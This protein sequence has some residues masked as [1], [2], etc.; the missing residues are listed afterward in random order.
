MHGFTRCYLLGIRFTVSP[1]LYQLAP[2]VR[3]IETTSEESSITLRVDFEPTA[4]YSGTLYCA[5]F[6]SSADITTVNTVV[7]RGKAVSYAA[8]SSQQS[9]TLSGLNALTSYTTFCHMQ[10]ALGFANSLVAVL[11][12][13]RTVSTTCCRKIAFT[14]APAF[15]YAD[16]AQYSGGGSSS[17]P[18]S[19]YVFSYELSNL[20][21]SSVTITPLLTLLESGSST[22]SSSREGKGEGSSTTTLLVAMPQATTFSATSMSKR[23][24]FLLSG[25]GSSSGGVYSLS[26][27]L[28]GS[29][30]TEFDAPTISLRV[31]SNTDAAPAP[32]F[33]H[34]RFSDS[35]AL[36]FMSFD[37]PTNQAQI[38]SLSFGCASLFVFDGAERATCNWVNSSTVRGILGVYEESS[39]LLSV[40]GNVTLLPELVRAECG[41]ATGGTDCTAFTAAP[42]RTVFAAAP[43][44]PVAPV[45]VLGVPSLASFC[46]DINIDPTLSSGTGGR[47]FSALQWSVTAANGEDTSAI[48]SA[49]EA[50]GVTTNAIL[51][52]P[53]TIFSLTR[54]SISLTL[55]NFLG[56]SGSA[57]A[58]LELNSN[59]NLPTVKLSGPSVV[60]INPSQTLAVYSET[61]RSG[62][63]ETP[64][65]TYSYAV[66]QDVLD[67]GLTSAGSDPTSLVLAPYTLELGAVYTVR[68]TATAAATANH[69]EATATAT[70]TV[71]VVDG[72]VVPVVAGGLSRLVS[73]DGPLLIDASRSYDENISP[74]S[75]SSGLSDLHFDWSCSIESIIAFGQDCSSL[76]VTPSANESMLIVDGTLLQPVN[77]YGFTLTVTADDGRSGATTITVERN[78][79]DVPYVEI[80]SVKKK[81]NSDAQL[82]LL[83]WLVSGQATN[84]CWEANINGRAVD[85]RTAAITPICVDFTAAQASSGI[86]FPLALPGNVL[87]QGST[88]TFRC[89]ANYIGQS[90]IGFSEVEIFVNAAPTGGSLTV[91]PSEGSALSTT[92]SLITFGWSDDIEDLP[93]TY[94]FFFQLQPAQPE[95]QVKL[96]GAPNTVATN[97]PV[98]PEAT[99]SSYTLIGVVFDQLS[100]SAR[101]VTPVTVSAASEGLDIS[102]YLNDNLDE[103]ARLGSAGLTSRTISSV[104]ATVNAVNCSLARPAF[105]AARHREPLPSR[106]RTRARGAWTAM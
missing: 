57:T 7:S 98:G 31:L 72:D 66:L 59:P 18:E 23:G 42:A 19:R 99:N 97:L 90:T 32:S 86:S 30:S 12:T 74:S 96:R 28:S 80:S 73:V 62:C 3:T 2:V 67:L 105:C 45:A 61:S 24:T 100:A 56:Q 69:P 29:S 82:N 83:G 106:R 75:S 40:G 47:P 39:V 63:S 41:A 15:I 71:V 58:Q 102:A 52:L 68:L 78:P 13:K 35:G 36:L 92:F 6:I 11:E 38:A 65:I 17:S 103:A 70:Q 46:G 21:G 5:A 27:A 4:E 1:T 33:T 53:P 8:G 25:N 93:L 95:Q 26:L 20:P 91:T 50:Y 94:E 22:G 81:V 16:L 88:V 87:T 104:A 37:S 84:A 51:S 49:L 54:Y 85:L 34:A 43:I 14:N 44:N 77:I 48:V 76:I 10:N 64:V 89:D 55:T 101:A 9:V 60:S 79:I